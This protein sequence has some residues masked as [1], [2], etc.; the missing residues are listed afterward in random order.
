M[1][2]HVL[3]DPHHQFAGRSFPTGPDV[4][5]NDALLVSDTDLHRGLSFKNKELFVTVKPANAR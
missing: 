3:A 1:D 2:R 4:E 5:L